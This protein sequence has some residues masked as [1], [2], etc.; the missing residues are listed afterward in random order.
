MPHNGTISMIPERGFKL[1]VD[2]LD[3]QSRNREK[4]ETCKVKT[5]CLDIFDHMCAQKVTTRSVPDYLSQFHKL[6]G[7]EK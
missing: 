3:K 5:A 1:I 2:Y 7:K 6:C 4:C